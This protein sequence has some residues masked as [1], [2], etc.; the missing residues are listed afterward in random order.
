MLRIKDTPH[1]GSGLLVD[2]PAVLVPRLLPVA[3]DRMVSGGLAS[4]APRLIRRTL[5]PAAIPQKPFVYDIKK[6]H[7]FSRTLV[8]T[9]HTIANGDEPDAL[10]PKEDLIVTLHRRV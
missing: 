2:Q 9:V 8:R 10:L 6:L 1:N 5:F 3:V 4:V 7:K